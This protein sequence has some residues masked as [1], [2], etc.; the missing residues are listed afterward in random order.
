[1]WESES[2]AAPAIGELCRSF[3]ATE[4]LT[5]AS[6][7]RTADRRTIEAR[8]DMDGATGSPGAPRRAEP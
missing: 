6:A 3:T 8:C 2:R 4:Q 5:L 1:M 7:A